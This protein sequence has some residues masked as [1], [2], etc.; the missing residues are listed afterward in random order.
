MMTEHAEQLAKAVHAVLGDNILIQDSLG[1]PPRLY[2]AA[3]EDPIYPYLTY[4]AMRSQ[5][6]GADDTLLSAHQMTLHVWSR[7]TG[8]AEI[9]GLLTRIGG[10]LTSEALTATGHIAVRS[11]NPI[12]SDILRAPDGLTRHGLLRMSFT[13]EGGLS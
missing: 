1:E 6:I 10:A 2:D 11:S 8:R 9:L 3:P 5:D 7:Y 13:T 12:Y 4:G